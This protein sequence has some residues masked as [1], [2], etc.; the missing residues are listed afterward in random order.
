MIKRVVVV[1]MF[2]TTI[3]LYAMDTH[4]SDAQVSA[5]STLSLSHL[6]VLLSSDI[7]KDMQEKWQASKQDFKDLRDSAAELLHNFFDESVSLDNMQINNQLV[8][9]KKLILFLIQELINLKKS[10]KELQRIVDKELVQKFTL[11]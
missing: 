6:S 5:P 7:K 2:G 9:Q 8:Q 4:S 1:L 11:S 10:H 3:S